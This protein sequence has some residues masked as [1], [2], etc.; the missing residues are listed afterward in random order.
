MKRLIILALALACLVVPSHAQ[1]RARVTQR[2]IVQLT[3]PDLTGTVTL[4]LPR[5]GPA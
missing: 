4:E 2:R 3:D 5:G 1:R